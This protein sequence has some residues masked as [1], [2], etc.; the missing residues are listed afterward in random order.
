MQL[1][2]SILAVLALQFAP[3]AMADDW[4]QWRGQDRDGICKEKGL[5]TKWPADGPPLAWDTKGLGTGF[6]SVAIAGG[7]IYTLGDLKDGSYAIALSEADGAP[8]WKT[9]IGDSGGH[10]KYP[11]TRSTP[12]V[13]GGQVFVLNQHSDIVCLDAKSGD[14]VWKKNLE[15]DFGGKMMS[16]WRYSESPLVDGDRVV[17]TPGGRDG[18]LLA[19]DRK[20]GAKLW[21]TRDWT[22]AAGYSSIIIATIHGARQYVQLTGKSVAGVEPE[23]G[24]VLWKAP[25]QGKTAVIPTPVVDGDIVFVTSGY[26]I[27]CNGFQI[28]RKGSAWSA[29]ELYANKEIANHHGGV[30]L[31][32]GHAYGTTGST[33]RCVEL[34]SGDGVFNERSAGKGSIL[35][36]G[37]RFI[38]RTENGAVSLIEASP[39]GMA[40]VSKFKQPD[41]SE[42][43]AWPHPVIANGKLYLRDQ[44]ILLC[45]DVSS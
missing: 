39:E 40:E 12:T 18:T 8:L 28:T 42:H 1:R 36:A 22:D 16:G 9:K 35:Y 44:D 5:L 41:R 19:L 37:G 4:P 24:R 43:K 45:Y 23:T 38:L 15:S 31:V 7:T 32:D 20:T 29:E 11:G 27:G 30:I 21:Q 10:R 34:E 6:S 14:L 17:C 25:R 26:G 13:D 33:F 2:L 3:T